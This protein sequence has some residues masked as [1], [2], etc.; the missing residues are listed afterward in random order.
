MF[1]KHS[2]AAGLGRL[3]AAVILVALAAA[4]LSASRPASGAEDER[5]AVAERWAGAVKERDGRAQYALLSQV[6]Q[7]RTYRAFERFDWVTGES[8]PW[9]SAYRVT[10]GRRGVTVVF[11]Y[12]SATGPAYRFCYRLTFTEEDGQTKI[13]A[14]SAPEKV[15]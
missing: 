8:S 13:A 2:I 7:K 12:A 11:E 15:G 5:L 4:L 6:L 1:R 3:I 14:I 9:V 10:A